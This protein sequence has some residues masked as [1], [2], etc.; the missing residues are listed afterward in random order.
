MASNDSLETENDPELEMSSAGFTVTPNPATG[1]VTLEFNPEDGPQDCIV[2]VYNM[3][4][5]RIASQEVLS[6]RSCQ[7]SLIDQAPGIYTIQVVREDRVDEVK[8]IKN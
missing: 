1:P 4:G 6:S 3:T 5:T 7:F 2:Q 8:I